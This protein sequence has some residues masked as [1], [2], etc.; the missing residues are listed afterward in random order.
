MPAYIVA[1]VSVHD[2]K[3]YKKYMA[4]TP[5]AIEAFGGKFIARGGEVITLE[6]PK[7]ERRVVLL[8]FPDIESAKA[9]YDS[10]QYQ[11]A[12]ALREGAAAGS[13]ILLEGV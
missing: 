10:E 11:T 2:M 12:K 9:F 3:Q 7:E 6:G 4:L 13:F 5:A 1:R 8:E